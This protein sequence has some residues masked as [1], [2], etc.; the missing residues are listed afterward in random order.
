MLL[1]TTHIAHIIK[2]LTSLVAKTTVQKHTTTTK[3]EKKCNQYNS[4]HTVP[5]LAYGYIQLYNA[6]YSKL[7]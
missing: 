5:C 1:K 2:L 7:N 4:Q 3:K 6:I